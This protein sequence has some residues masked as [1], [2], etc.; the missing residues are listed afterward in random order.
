MRCR[1]GDMAIRLLIWS[2]HFSYFFT[3]S[4]HTSSRLTPAGE[5]PLA[6][7][8]AE[9]LTVEPPSGP[10]IF[11]RSFAEV[12]GRQLVKPLVFVPT[13]I[14]SLNQDDQPISWRE[15]RLKSRSRKSETSL[16]GK[17]VT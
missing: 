3:P 10:Q 4:T 13:T 7:T 14:S 8:S 12:G 9:P 17:F 15:S 1:P 6:F 5:F 2:F 11:T 16:P